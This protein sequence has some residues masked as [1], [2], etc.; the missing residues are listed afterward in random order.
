M[1]EDA[2]IKWMTSKLLRCPDCRA[3]VRHNVGVHYPDGKEVHVAECMRCH[4]L[5]PLED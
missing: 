4:A 2:D 1:V 5:R 3:Q